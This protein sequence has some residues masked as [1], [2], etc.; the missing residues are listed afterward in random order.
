[1]DDDDYYEASSVKKRV[2]PLYYNKTSKI[3]ACTILGCFAINKYKSYIEPPDLFGAAYKKFRIGSMA[4]RRE[5][6]D[7]GY[8]SDSSNERSKTKHICD[9]K[10]IH[11]MS[12]I[13]ANI[14]NIIE[15]SGRVLLFRGFS[16]NTTH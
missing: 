5:I 15:V 16:K 14:R 4:F 10:S 3:V 7:F 8:M 2:A 1:M 11:E 13:P 6:F 12:S 9:D